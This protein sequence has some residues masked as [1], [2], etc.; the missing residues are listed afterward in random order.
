[1]GDRAAKWSIA[2]LQARGHEVV[3]ADAAAL[4]LPVLDKMWKEIKDDEAEAKSEL[5]GNLAG[6][7]QS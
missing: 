1:M 6:L 5:H 4:Q 2:Q 3:L 7:A